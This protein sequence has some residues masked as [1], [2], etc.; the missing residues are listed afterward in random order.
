MHVGVM[1]DIDQILKYC[2]PEVYYP[3]FDSKYHEVGIVK[4]QGSVLGAIIKK[5]TSYSDTEWFFV[6]YEEFIFMVKKMEIQHLL[7]NPNKNKMILR[8]AEI[9]SSIERINSVDA[10]F[11]YDV[12]FNCIPDSARIPCAICSILQVDGIDTIVMLIAS[13][14][15]TERLFQLI[16]QTGGTESKSRKFINSISAIVPFRHFENFVSTLA[17]NGFNLSCCMESSDNNTLSCIYGSKIPKK[18]KESPRLIHEKV[19]QLVR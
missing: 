14:S 9:N 12:V 1:D 11:R 3:E 17:A 18:F 19:R 13:G 8:K 15:R 4:E 7:W 2:L 10:Y 16:Q 5:G 6:S